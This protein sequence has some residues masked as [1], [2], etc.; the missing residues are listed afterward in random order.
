MTW[1]L[2]AALL[3][4]GLL[5]PVPAAV[6]AL[7]PPADEA[8]LAQTLAEAHTEQDVCYGWVVHINGLQ[9]D[10][11]SSLGPGVPL[12]TAV[13]RCE[14]RVNLEATLTY[15]CDVCEGED[16]ADLAIESNLRDPPTVKDLED[17]GYSA[18]D[19]VGNKDDVTLIDM[20]GAL[21]LLTAQRGNAPF[22]EYEAATSVPARD[23]PTD[24]PGSDLLRD[25]WFALVLFGGLLVFGPAWFFYKRSQRTATNPAKE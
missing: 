7:L 22:I 6:G 5:A 9:S 23:G 2:L 8:E 13:A 11:G 3:A 14:R 18:S 12:G 21:P 20:V 1:R 10:L 16:S 19:L 17:L 25:R 15:T 4:L 24:T